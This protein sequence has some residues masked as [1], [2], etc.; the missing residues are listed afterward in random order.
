MSRDKDKAGMAGIPFVSEVLARRRVA[1]LE[2][3]VARFRV[4]TSDALA[5][6]GTECAQQAALQASA[7]AAREAALSLS[8]QAGEPLLRR[9]ER[10]EARIESMKIACQL[11]REAVSEARDTEGTSLSGG[12]EGR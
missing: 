12:G 4:R 1:Q 6:L 8:P 2:K 9:I 5:K 11:P 3:R 7:L 10:Q